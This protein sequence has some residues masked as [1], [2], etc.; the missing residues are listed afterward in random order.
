MS[1]DGA[2]ASGDD[3]NW[4]EAADQLFADLAADWSP[5]GVP[6]VQHLRFV[7]PR[8]HLRT[9]C[10]RVDVRR[11]IGLCSLLPMPACHPVPPLAP[12]GAGLFGRSGGRLGSARGD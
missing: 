5:E 3:E 7:G 10:L 1:T 11:M 9:R 12:A 2:R 8:I 6:S 4:R